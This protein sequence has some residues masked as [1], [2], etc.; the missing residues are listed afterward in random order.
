MTPHLDTLG[1]TR[2]RM[3]IKQLEARVKALE[4]EKYILREWL[5]SYITDNVVICAD[6]GRAFPRKRKA[7]KK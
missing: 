6:C 3:Q 4:D 1:G 5:R 7:R 2:Q